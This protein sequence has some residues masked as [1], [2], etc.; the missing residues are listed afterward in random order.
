MDKETL[1]LFIKA[2]QPNRYKKDIPLILGIRNASERR[3]TGPMLLPNTT[4]EVVLRAT[5][6]SKDE[7][8]EEVILNEQEISISQPSNLFS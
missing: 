1:S 5:R 4:D 2:I 6:M 3:E 8:A 7:E